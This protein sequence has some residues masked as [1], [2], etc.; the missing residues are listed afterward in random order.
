MPKQI[1]ALETKLSESIAAAAANTAAATTTTETMTEDQSEKPNPSEHSTPSAAAED[2]EGDENDK[3]DLEVDSEAM[4]AS[5][6]GERGHTAEVAGSE[7]ADASSAEEGEQ[8]KQQ[9]MLLLE[10]QLREAQ[11]LGQELRAAAG[12]MD[13]VLSGLREEK[14]G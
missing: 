13:G 12:E 14:V 8:H 9:R 3:A 2:P 5:G 11:S 1:A 10:T 6:D 4:A 7:A